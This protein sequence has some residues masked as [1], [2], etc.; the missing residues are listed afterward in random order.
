MFTRAIKTALVI[1]TNKLT[2]KSCFTNPA[3]VKNL[4]CFG[5]E[6]AYSA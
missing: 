1:I 2:K 6:K 5:R 3:G 4:K